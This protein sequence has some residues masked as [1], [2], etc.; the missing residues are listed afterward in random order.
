MKQCE[1]VNLF[2]ALRF[3][4]IALTIFSVMLFVKNGSL[5]GVMAIGSCVALV[6]AYHIFAKVAKGRQNI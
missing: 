4:F 1:V 3:V 6:V 2:N 5:A